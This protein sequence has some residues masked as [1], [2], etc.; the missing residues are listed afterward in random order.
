MTLCIAMT[1]FVICLV[2]S[3]GEFVSEV[4]LENPVDFTYM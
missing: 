1:E 2:D 3:D 4:D